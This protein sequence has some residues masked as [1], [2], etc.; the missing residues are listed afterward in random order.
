MES[1]LAFAEPVEAGAGENLGLSEAR[2]APRLLGELEGAQFHVIHAY[3][4][5]YGATSLRKSL[6]NKKRSKRLVVRN[7]IGSVILLL[8]RVVPLSEQNQ[9]SS[10]RNRPCLHT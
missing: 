3:C 2:S 9:D 1:H 10:S 8:S 6:L 7:C 5:R 4:F